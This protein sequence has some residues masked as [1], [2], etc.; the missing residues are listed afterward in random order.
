MSNNISKN[1]SEEYEKMSFE[2]AMEA[3]EIFDDSL[4]KLSMAMLVK[5]IL[6]YSNEK[7]SNA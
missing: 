2:E 4:F 1:P 3:L 7:V 5:F 6:G